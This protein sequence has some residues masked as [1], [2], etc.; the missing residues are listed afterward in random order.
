M[1]SL[2]RSAYYGTNDTMTK[3]IVPGWAFVE[4]NSDALTI[5]KLICKSPRRKAAHLARL[6]AVLEPI[7]AHLIRFF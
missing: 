7:A 6:R 1:M 4:V 3:S 5:M 2:C